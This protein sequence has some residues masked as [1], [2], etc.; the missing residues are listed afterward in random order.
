VFIF[1]SMT[2]SFR[3]TSQQQAVI[4]HNT[5]PALVFAVAGAGKTTA[6]VHRIERLVREGVF[7]AERI[8]ATSFA[9]ANVRDLRAAMK[10]WPH[11]GRVHL[12]T[13]HALGYQILRQAQAQ[14]HVRGLRLGGEDDEEGSGG[15][16]ILGKTLTEARRR[17][18]PFKKELD[19]LDWTDFLA[20]VGYCKGNL[21]YSHL[22]RANLPAAAHKLAT[23][24]EP[25]T[26]LS[27]YLDLY[28]LYEEVRQSQ[29]TITFD[30]MLLT[31]WECL[32]RFPPL[33]AD[34]RNLY[35][36]VLVDEFQD[37]NLVQSELLDLLTPQRNYMAI[38]DDDQTIYEWRGVDADENGHVVVVL[39][40]FM[41]G[42]DPAH[43]FSGHLGYILDLVQAGFAMKPL[44]QTELFGVSFLVEPDD[45]ISQHQ[46]RG[47]ATEIVVDQIGGGFVPLV[48]AQNETRISATPFINGL[49]IITNRHVVAL[50]GE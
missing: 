47:W 49:V 4:D 44:G 3:P 39:A 46:R 5:G 20:Y 21:H 29:G 11:C 31:A 43:N 18:V 41:R 36:C 45:L 1:F 2:N 35:Q 42:R 27:W 10:Q 37:I 14:G 6:M 13:L 48:E 8:L 33:L 22:E 7:P 30:D 28:R 34:V 16:A 26:N 24:A 40:L 50:R 32:L 9:R 19:G 12:R 17:N 23:Q 38:G 25:P 15:Q